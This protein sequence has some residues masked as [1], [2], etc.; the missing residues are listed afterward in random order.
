MTIQ[1][2]RV[3][4]TFGLRAEDVHFL[5]PLGGGG[6]DDSQGSLAVPT[7]QDP[8]DL[9]LEAFLG[10][11]LLEETLIQAQEPPMTGAAAS[12]GG[13]AASV[14]TVAVEPDVIEVLAGKSTNAPL[15]ICKRRRLLPGA[16]TWT[17]D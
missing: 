9:A 12:S 15:D 1:R 10:P 13:P 2:A 11:T 7:S 17:S 3:R 6:L 8:F 5:D 4:E 16:D 14:D